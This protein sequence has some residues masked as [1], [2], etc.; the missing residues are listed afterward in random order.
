MH[1]MQSYLV[2]LQVFLLFVFIF[3]NMNNIG[4]SICPYYLQRFLCVKRIQ[5]IETDYYF[6]LNNF[7]KDKTV[8][9]KRWL[10]S[11]YLSSELIGLRWEAHNSG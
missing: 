3:V 1:S 6:P 4:L 9:K 11:V 8:R 2:G 5:T 7:L 10:I